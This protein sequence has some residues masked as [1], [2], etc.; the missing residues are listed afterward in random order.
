MRGP[1]GIQMPLTDHFDV[2]RSIPK[3]CGVGNFL[4]LASRQFFSPLFHGGRSLG[5]ENPQFFRPLGAGF[6]RG[7]INEQ[8]VLDSIH[9]FGSVFLMGSTAHTLTLLRKK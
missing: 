1:F 9:G 2:V 4:I 3:S 6:I 8:K 5:P 7:L